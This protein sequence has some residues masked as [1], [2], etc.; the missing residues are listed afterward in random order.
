VA[1]GRHHVRYEKPTWASLLRGAG[2]N[3]KADA[4]IWR[5]A[6]MTLPRCEATVP[7]SVA[8]DSTERESQRQYSLNESN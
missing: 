1:S 6:F 5:L 7:S 3:P 8:T 2:E 4:A